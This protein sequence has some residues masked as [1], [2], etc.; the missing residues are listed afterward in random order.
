[1]KANATRIVLTDPPPLPKDA[2]C[3]QCGA[4]REARV[5]S[6]TF[7]PDHDMCNACGYDFDELTVPA[8]ADD[9]MR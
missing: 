7:G 5:R 1:M 8:T 9:T 6:V 4:G 2:R 3:P